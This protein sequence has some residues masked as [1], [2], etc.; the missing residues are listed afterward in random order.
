MTTCNVC[1][2]YVG[3]GSEKG[4]TICNECLS[5]ASGCSAVSVN[6]VLEFDV[7]LPAYRFWVRDNSGDEIQIR[8]EPSGMI[9][10]CYSQ[11]DRAVIESREITWDYFARSFRSFVDRLGDGP[12]A[13]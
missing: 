6:E 1:S 8:R 3:S 5:A 10:V 9:Y 2:K 13:E 12:D 4:G 7:E 11:K